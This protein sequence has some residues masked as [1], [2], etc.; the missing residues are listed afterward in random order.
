MTF[1]W[2]EKKWSLIKATLSTGLAELVNLAN[3]KKKHI[4]PNPQKFVKNIKNAFYKTPIVPY[5][6]YFKVMHSLEHFSTFK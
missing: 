2:A 5:Q 4:F 6:N 3:F 1:Y